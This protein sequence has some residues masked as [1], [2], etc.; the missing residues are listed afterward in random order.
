MLK[1]KWCIYFIVSFSNYKKRLFKK[2][3]LL[4]SVGRNLLFLFQSGRIFDIFFV[5]LAMGSNLIF[6]NVGSFITVIL[7]RY[8]WLLAVGS[9][10]CSLMFFSSVMIVT[11][12]SWSGRHFFFRSLAVGSKSWYKLYSLNTVD[13]LEQIYENGKYLLHGR[14]Y[15]LSVGC[16]EINRA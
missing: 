12:I 7:G 13:K 16:L 9:S 14:K 8:F 11:C 15:S 1:G 10:T 2:I 5:T 4:K 3:V 6:Y